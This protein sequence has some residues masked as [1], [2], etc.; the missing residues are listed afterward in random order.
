MIPWRRIRILPLLIFVAA[1]SFSIRLG[2]FVTGFKS[3]SGAAHAE[4]A[5]PPEEPLQ[6]PG[7]PGA[8]PPEKDAAEKEDAGKDAAGDAPAKDDKKAETAATPEKEGEAKEGEPKAA[9]EDPAV[10]P[11]SKPPEWKDSI[12]SEYEF[13]DVRME[14]FEDLANRRKELDEREREQAL[15]EALLKAAEQEIA[16]KYK[17][18]ELLKEEIQALLQTQS[19]EEKARNASLV[20]IY[21]GM[22]AKDAARIF[23]TLDMDVLLRVLG[24]MSE[25]KSAPIIA[26][27]DADRART[28]TIMLAEQKRLPNLS[29]PLLPQN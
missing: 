8:A 28:V 18:L 21:E 29:E 4:N 1:L 27:M 17:E 7:K 20:K 19:E 25:R 16:Q 10:P 5:A 14:L 24:Q 13:S 3:Y 6:E 2:E 22:K 15:R 23:N 11:A 12:E 9:M 26:A